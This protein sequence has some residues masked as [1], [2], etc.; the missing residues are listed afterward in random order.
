MKAG[1]Q[2][3]LLG[4]VLSSCS[5]PADPRTGTI[6]NPFLIPVQAM[7]L[8]SRDTSLSPSDQID[9]YDADPVDMSGPE[10]LYEFSLPERMEVT[11][12]LADDSGVDV[13][14]YLLSS[15]SP[16]TWIARHGSTLTLT[17]DPGTYFLS[18]DTVVL[19]GVPQSGAYDLTVSFTPD[20]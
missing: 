8:D 15:L 2:L 9:S 20:P 13:D 5:D 6:T 12:S 7:Y 16:V 4:L 3:L 17:L 19:A 10:Y 18:I 14:V 1:I 11:A